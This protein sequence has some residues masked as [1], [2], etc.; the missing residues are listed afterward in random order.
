MDAAEATDSM[1]PL[2]GCLL[3]SD[4]TRNPEEWPK[5]TGE[6]KGTQKA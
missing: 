1:K 2:A 5:G 3:W 4:L 6:K